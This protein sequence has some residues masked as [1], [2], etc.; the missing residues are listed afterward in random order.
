MRRIEILFMVFV[1]A[2]I[3]N[4]C[5]KEENLEKDKSNEKEIVTFDASSISGSINENDHTINIAVPYGTDV[6]ATAPSITVSSGA[7]ISPESGTAQNFTDPVTY[8]VTAEDGS[9]QEYVVSVEVLESGNCSILEFAIEGLTPSVAGVIDEANNTINLVVPKETD[10]TTLIPTIGISDDAVIS[11]ESGELQNF[12]DPVL[13]TVTAQDGTEKE[14][15]VNITLELSGENSIKEFKFEEFSPALESVI[16]ED[17]KTVTVLIP[18]NIEFTTDYDIYSMAPT[19]IVS[20]GA[21][22]DPE[23]GV[24]ENFNYDRTYTVTAENGDRQDYSVI[25]NKE[26]APSATVNLPLT[27]TQYGIG[28]FIE[29]SGT[30][31]TKDCSVTLGN[32]ITS[33]VITEITETS[34]KIS[35]ESSYYFPAGEMDV[36]LRIR[37]QEFDLGTLKF[38]P[39]P[40]T[41]TQFS[42]SG[43]DGNN[44]L[45]IG[46]TNFSEGNNEVY[47][48]GN[49]INER[50]YIKKEN[51]ETYIYVIIPPFIPTGEYNIKV[52]AD[53]QDATSAETV[54]VTMSSETR[55]VITSVNKL[56]IADGETLEIHGKNFTSFNEAGGS[57]NVMWMDG[58]SA[59]RNIF[60]TIISDEKIEVVID[61]SIL[62]SDNKYEFYLD[63]GWPDISKNN[64]YNIQV[65]D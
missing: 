29:I 14:Y 1:T 51:G 8:T 65:I 56:T 13:Y 16:D 5:E 22:I 12:S 52:V 60:G 55:P 4:G 43:S 26:E 2:I 32:S 41:F 62:A 57:V 3:F 34:L 21:T 46:G 28:D 45:T 38:L 27:I 10:V 59:T 39:P 33:E 7:T 23:S 53:G 40:P 48:V 6:S 19:I 35:V 44:I 15:H 47:F 54:S 58:W 50:A 30:N 63:F 11:P 64:F 36:K 49:G 24:S 9:T 25:V 18:W 17:N 31:F 42:T 37:E 20:E 61:R